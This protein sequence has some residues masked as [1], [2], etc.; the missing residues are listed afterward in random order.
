[1]AKVK[2]TSTVMIQ[3]V[4]AGV[5]TKGDKRFNVL[6]VGMHVGVAVLK[7]LGLKSRGSSYYYSASAI[8]I[9]GTT[10]KARG[11]FESEAI[12]NVLEGILQEDYQN[13]RH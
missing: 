10:I 2:I 7:N 6:L 13:E 3:A 8:L 1:M 9:D 5:S 4:P 11:M 12:R